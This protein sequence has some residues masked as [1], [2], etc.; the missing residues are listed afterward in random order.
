MYTR[1]I[2]L[3]FLAVLAGNSVQADI[4]S[5]VNPQDI[6]VVGELQ[7]SLTQSALE[8][9]KGIL[10]QGDFK[11]A[12]DRIKEIADSQKDLPLPELIISG[13][14]FELNYPVMGTQVLQ[15]VGFSH[16]HRQ[17]VQLQ[18]A[19]MA[20]KQARFYEASLH[21]ESALKAEPE[22]EWS[23]GYRAFLVTTMH[24]T[25]GAIEERRERFEEGKEIYQKLLEENPQSI[26]AHI[27]H[28]RCSFALGDIDAAELHFREVEKIQGEQAPVTEVALATLFLGKN[29][30]AS[31]EEWFR[32]GLDVQRNTL[33]RLEYARLLLKLNRPEDA[34][35]VLSKSKPE[36]PLRT[37]FIF[38]IGQAEQMM[39]NFEKT[40]PIFQHLWQTHPSNLVIANHLAWA[41]LASEDRKKFEQGIALARQNANN[42]PGSIEALATYA[43]GQFK[44]GDLKGAEATINRPIPNRNFSRDAAYFYSEIL[45]KLDKEEE[46]ERIR[47]SVDTAIGEF[48]HQRL[49]A[50]TDGNPD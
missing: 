15:Q 7:S 22:E 30:T 34:R 25:R 35:E 46:A 14:L 1:S 24:E 31:A 28:A 37:E 26:K 45:K 29:D 17:D 48:F 16:G 43:W 8:E 4:L 5:T 41:L 23:P 2:T 27:G 42:F 9:A 38:H 6:R 44:N 10:V 11:G 32:K 47:K 50:P 20:M 33:V 12:R 36:E 49:L 3:L 18:M 13:W 21:V 19:Q 40:I 39:G